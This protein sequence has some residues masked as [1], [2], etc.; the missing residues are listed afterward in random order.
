MKVIDFRT[1][2]RALAVFAIFIA[3]GTRFVVVSNL[4]SKY[5]LKGFLLV[6]YHEYV[7]HE[8]C[9]EGIIQF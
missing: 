4:L 7:I 1:S 2:Q 8:I 6:H 5:I 3:I 9:K